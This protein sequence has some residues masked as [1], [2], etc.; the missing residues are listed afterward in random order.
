MP[1]LSWLSSSCNVE[2]ESATWWRRFRQETAAGGCGFGA[3]FHGAVERRCG[4]SEAKVRASYRIFASLLLCPPG[5]LLTRKLRLRPDRECG[6]I[7]RLGLFKGLG[8]LSTLRR[9]RRMESKAT[10]RTALKSLSPTSRDKKMRP[11]DSEC[12]SRRN[13]VRIEAPCPL[14]VLGW[15]TPS[16]AGFEPQPFAFVQRLKHCPLGRVVG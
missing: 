8:G 16:M 14:I 7:K 1:W 15:C 3:L 5:Q 2:C 10:R 13:R 6:K 11:N 4:F 9:V 12:K